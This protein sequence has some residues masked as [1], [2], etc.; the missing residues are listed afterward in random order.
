MLINI[1][2]FLIID[3]TS[4]NTLIEN[5]G[6]N[7]TVNDPCYLGTYILVNIFAYLLIFLCIKI[8]LFMYYQLFSRKEIF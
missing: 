8:I 2:K 5:L 4:F 1:E 3:I 6:C 7:L